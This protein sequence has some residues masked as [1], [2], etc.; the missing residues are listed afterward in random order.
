MAKVYL[1]LLCTFGLALSAATNSC[2]KDFTIGNFVF[3]VPST[4]NAPSYQYYINGSSIK[5]L[6]RLDDLAFDKTKS[7]G[8]LNSWNWNYDCGANYCQ[9]SDSCSFSFYGSPKSAPF[10]NITMKTVVTAAGLKFTVD[11]SGM[12]VSTLLATNNQLSYSFSFM[13]T[14]GSCGNPVALANKY[15]TAGLYSTN[16]PGDLSIFTVFGYSI[17]MSNSTEKLCSIDSLGTSVIT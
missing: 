7:I 13:C 12:G 15:Q 11:L 9:S 4:N 17:Y 5:Y 16:S 6:V 14:Q 3:K 2:D 10:Y 1:L 8:Q